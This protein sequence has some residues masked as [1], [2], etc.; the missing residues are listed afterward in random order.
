MKA[1]KLQ[2]ILI[3]G[4]IAL[5]VFVSVKFIIQDYKFLRIEFLNHAKGQ[6]LHFINSFIN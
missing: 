4:L 1:K 5:N 3:S 6:T 2:A